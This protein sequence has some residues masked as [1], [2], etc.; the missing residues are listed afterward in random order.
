MTPDVKTVFLNAR[1]KA[2][3]YILKE[4]LGQIKCIENDK[5]TATSDKLLQIKKIRDE[6][7]KVGTEIDSIKKEIKIVQ[8]HKLN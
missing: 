1:L 4:Y 2:Y 6:L 8:T 7:S 5:E 3:V